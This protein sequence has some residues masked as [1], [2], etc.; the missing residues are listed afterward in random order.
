MLSWQQSAV[1]CGACRGNIN[2][3]SRF[4][5]L[6]KQIQRPVRFAYSFGSSGAFRISGVPFQASFDSDFGKSH[7]GYHLF[8]TAMVLET[9]VVDNSFA[10]N[11]HP[12]GS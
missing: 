6:G 10:R 12:D 3:E 5:L 1:N 2:C 8:L 7:S 11:S 9:Q 4:A